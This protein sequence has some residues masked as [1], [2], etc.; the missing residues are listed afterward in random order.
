MSD[1]T[2]EE[3]EA[4]RPDFEILIVEVAKKNQYA[5]SNLVLRRDKDTGDYRTTW[6]D[7]AWLGFILGR[8][9]SPEKAIK[10]CDGCQSGI[11]VVDGMHTYDGEV[12]GFGC[13]AYR[14]GKDNDRCVNYE[15]KWV[16]CGDV[17]MDNGPVC[18]GKY[19][20]K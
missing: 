6:V 15:D 7:M 1:I 12:F 10:Q 11:P 20:P 18:C 4:N 9:S 14:Y 2:K 3:M 17:Q 8:Q 19:E 5:Y 13:T 16:C